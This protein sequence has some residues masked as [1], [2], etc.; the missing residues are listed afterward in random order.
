VAAGVALAPPVETE[1]PPSSEEGNAT[2]LS[3]AQPIKQRAITTILLY[4]I[5]P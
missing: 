3:L 5:F 4:I 2:S 1:I